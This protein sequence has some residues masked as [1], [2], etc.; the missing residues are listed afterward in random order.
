MEQAVSGSDEADQ[1]G[2][3]RRAMSPAQS[4]AARGLLAWS[5]AE[6]AAKGG[7]EERIVHAFEDGTGDPD[8]GRIE[9]LRSTFMAAG[10]VFEDEA[11]GVRLGGRAGDEGTRLDALTTE[12]DR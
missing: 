10:I 4:R 1:S 2:W 11:D 8:A 9:A 3:S 5:A 7:V 6:L 12:N